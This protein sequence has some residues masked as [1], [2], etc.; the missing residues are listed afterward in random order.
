M[1]RSAAIAFIESKEVELQRVTRELDELNLRRCELEEE[2]AK[3]QRCVRLLKYV[4]PLQQL[5]EKEK[6]KL[7]DRQLRKIAIHLPDPPLPL[8]SKWIRQLTLYFG[9]RHR[10]HIPPHQVVE[11]GRS[12]KG[13][14]MIKT[15]RPTDMKIVT[16][17]FDQ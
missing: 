17:T 2:K 6:W 16:I 3:L 12:K 15:I 5:R 14:L 1:E 13:M 7:S 11:V 4:S 9:T 10:P 8:P